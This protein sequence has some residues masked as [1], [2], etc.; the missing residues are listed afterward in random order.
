MTNCAAGQQDAQ[1]AEDVDSGN[2]THRLPHF[3]VPG[4]VKQIIYI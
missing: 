1:K 2:G 3:N 4:E